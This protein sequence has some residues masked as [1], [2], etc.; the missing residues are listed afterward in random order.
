MRF[1]GKPNGVFMKGAPGSYEQGKI[2]EVPFHYSQWKFWE[3]VEPP[4][5]LKVPDASKEDSV[6]SGE[7][8]VPPTGSILETGPSLDYEPHI[9]P[10]KLKE[11]P[12]PPKKPLQG[13]GISG[14]SNEKVGLEDDMPSELKAELKMMGEEIGVVPPVEIGVM[15]PVDIGVVPVVDKPK[16]GRRPKVVGPA[17][18][19]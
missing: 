18:N 6:F 3:L 4:P 11:V 10:E 5:E 15:P 9:E 13:G 2:Y 16:R 19:A 8:I 14:I 12:K 1:V 17:V 7:A